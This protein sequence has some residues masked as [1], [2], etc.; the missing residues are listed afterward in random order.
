MPTARARRS[1]P[2]AV[3]LPPRFERYSEKSR[4]V[5]TILESVTPLVEQLSIDEAFLDV[6]GVRRQHGTGEQVAALLR[7]RVRAETGLT[8]SVG[9][10]TTKFLAKLASD[11]S[12][13]DGLLADR[14]GHRA[15]VP[16]PAP[17]HPLVGSRPRDLP[18]TRPHGSAHDRRRRAARRSDSRPRARVVA[19][20]ASLCPRAQ[21]RRT[22][23]RA[24]PRHQVDRGGG[25][26]RHR[27][28]HRC[29]MPARARPARR[30]RRHTRARR[31][32]TSRARS[33]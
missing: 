14:A 15:R 13:P 9:V 8:L 23:R 26:L 22:R 1:C 21:R 30:S 19:R 31:G 10:A 24:R 11:L 3:F 7:Q 27:P 6:G 17:R 18:Y 2:H 16:R 25:D 28:A 32:S 12:K 5:M 29:G 4:E 33:P 20:H